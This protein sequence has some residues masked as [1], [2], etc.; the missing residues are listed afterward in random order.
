VK[1]GG[2]ITEPPEMLGVDRFNDFGPVIRFMLKTK[3][4]RMFAVKRELLRRIKKSFEAHGIE[5]Q[6][7][8]RIAL[9]RP[10]APG[11]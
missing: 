7:P 8:N 1:F 4:D 10:A 11:A 9:Q 6:D 5:I 3:A 2:Y